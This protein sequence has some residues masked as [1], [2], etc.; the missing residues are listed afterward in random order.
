MLHFTFNAGGLAV[1]RVTTAFCEVM[2]S[3]A[4]GSDLQSI[5]DEL[6]IKNIK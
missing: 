3:R 4:I 5:Q 1:V 2:K 6:Q